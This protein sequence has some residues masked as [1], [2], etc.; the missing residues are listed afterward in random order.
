DQLQEHLSKL[1]RLA[2]ERCHRLERSK[3]L[4]AYMRE[5]DEFEAWIGE[6]MQTASSEE[7]G[8]DYEHLEVSLSA[9]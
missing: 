3:R 9:V 2:A 4:H 5:A 7:Y 1:K 6:Q 8:Q